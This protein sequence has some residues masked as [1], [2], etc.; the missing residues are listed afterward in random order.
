MTDNVPPPSTV[1]FTPLA[2]YK[3]RAA[4]AQPYLIL[5]HWTDLAS[6]HGLVLMRGEISDNVALSETDAQLLAVR[7]QLF[8]NA[9]T[10]AR[11]ETIDI[12][13]A[14][15]ALAAKESQ[16]QPSTTTSTPVA[17]SAKE[18]ERARM[19]E[20]FHADPANFDTER[21]VQMAWELH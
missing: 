20:S 14:Q 10:G 8:Y 16:E 5:T 18:Q 3:T 17:P 12:P 4:Y 6:S 21:L 19:L 13:P 15:A 2:E 9:S 1:L 7:L 11:V